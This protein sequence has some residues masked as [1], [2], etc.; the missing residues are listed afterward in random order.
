[1]TSVLV[2]GGSGRLGRALLDRLVEAGYDVRAASRTAR[3]PGGG[4]RWTVLDLATGAGVARA[5]EGV[6]VIVH[7]ASMP[8]KGRY[9][10][11]VELG[12]TAELLAA[13]REAGTAH[14]V[15]TSIV[16]VDQVPWG[17]FRTKLRAERLVQEGG[18]P[19]T[20]VRITQFHSF[21]EEVLR[22]MARLG[23]LVTD[24]GVTVRPV[25]VADAAGHLVSVVERGP[26]S[27]IE[28]Y[29]GPE[30]LTMSEMAE[31]WLR[32]RRL[33]RLVLRLRLP[34]GLGRAARAGHLVTKAEP[35]G[36]ITWADHLRRR[37][38]R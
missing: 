27:R 35:A 33:R 30:V 21:V 23:V 2:T 14:F 3:D 11:R 26:G 37:R 18:V 16:G 6:D 7:L 4:V 1:M 25:D 22:G 13:A 8:Y 20:T 15:Y 31:A 12:G 24:P 32:A 34:G 29:A 36:T 17:Y 19:W 5:V 9:T 28:E 10:R 38:A